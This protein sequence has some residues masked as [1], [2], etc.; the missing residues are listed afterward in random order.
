MSKITKNVHLALQGGGAHGAYTWGILD[1]ILEDGRLNIDGLCATSAGAFNA[2]I[3]SYGRLKGGNDGAREA[4]HKF[5]LAVSD[6]GNHT[7]DIPTPID[8]LIL[9]WNIS[10]FDTLSHVVSPYQFNPWNK[11]ILRDILNNLV[12]FDELKQAKSTALFISATNVRNGKVKVFKTHELSTDVILASSCL[13]YLFQAVKVG[14]EFYWDGGFTG[15]PAIFPL[16]YLDEKTNDIIIVHI[17]PMVRSKLPTL[18]NEIMNR[19]NEITFNSS[20]LNE[21]RAI[22]FVKKMFNEGWL[23]PEFEKKLR[24][25]HIHSIRADQALHD[26]DATSKYDTHWHFLTSLRDLGRI[27]AKNWLD[28]NFDSIGKISTVNLHKDFLDDSNNGIV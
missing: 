17:N 27:E 25:I 28:Q 15:N 20:L 19:I 1:K 6:A 18:S 3:L 10:V 22:A 16:F 24:D 26:F 12:D 14:D 4:L 9:Y 21:F 23:K 5:W 2:A 7:N 11:N 8:N 13:P